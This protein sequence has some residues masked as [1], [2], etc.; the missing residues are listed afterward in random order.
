MDSARRRSD[1]Q[2]EAPAN[3]VG[4][5]T[6]KTTEIKRGGGRKVGREIADKLVVKLMV[7]NETPPPSTNFVAHQPPS[8]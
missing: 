7:Y 3:E 8:T 6:T 4:G 5:W 1:P 2:L